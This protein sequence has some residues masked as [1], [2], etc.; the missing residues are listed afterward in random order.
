MDPNHKSFDYCDHCDESNPSISLVF[1]LEPLPTPYL[2]FTPDQLLVTFSLFAGFLWGESFRGLDH[3]IR[4]SQ[5]FEI[6]TPVQ[7]YLLAWIPDLGHHFQYGMALMWFAYQAGDVTVSS[8]LYYFGLGIVL[9]DV[10][11]Y[12]A[13]LRRITS[14]FSQ[15][16]GFEAK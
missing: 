15:M 8:F 1:K 10:K 14:A 11:N 4:K 16:K 9:A 3:A 12:R 7:R 2:V 6:M 5:L 13:V